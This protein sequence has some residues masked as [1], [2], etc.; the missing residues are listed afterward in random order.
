MKIRFDLIILAL[1]LACLFFLPA[2]L[3]ADDE[4]P[5]TNPTDHIAVISVVNRIG[6]AA[7]MNDWQAVKACFADGVL[8]DYTSMT[9]GEP[10]TLTPEQIV[11]AWRKFLPGFEL[12]KHTITNHE[13]T[14]KGDAAEC[15]AYVNALHFIRG[16]KGG[17][18]W[19][20]HGFYNSHLVKTTAGWKVDAMKFTKTLIE[21]NL[22]LPEIA[23]KRVQPK[24]REVKFRSAGVPMVGKLY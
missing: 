13:V 3:I 1:T 19:T 18:T 15:F 9:G 20:V 4:S 17:E 23:Q 2:V 10:A 22:K 14:I 21:G 11:T 24:V 16:S 8:L 12:T 5:K 6:T 7:D